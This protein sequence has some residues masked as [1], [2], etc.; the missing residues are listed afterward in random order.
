MGT[1]GF[2]RPWGHRSCW[3]LNQLEHVDGTDAADPRGLQHSRHVRLSQA[4]RASRRW[5]QLQEIP[6]PGL[7][8]GRTQ[9]EQRGIKTVQLLPPL[10][11]GAAELGEQRVFRPAEFSYHQEVRFL[12]V[13]LAKAGPVCT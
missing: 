13:Y 10:V 8:S 5:S 9:L 6:E 3:G 12:H 2:G 11:R 7:I 1:G 4:R